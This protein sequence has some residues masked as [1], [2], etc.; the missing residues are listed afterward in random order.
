MVIE[1]ESV[2]S[3]TGQAENHTPV[4]RDIIL[5]NQRGRIKKLKQID[6]TSLMDQKYRNWVPKSVKTIVNSKY[7]GGKHII[8]KKCQTTVARGFLW[9]T[10]IRSVKLGCAAT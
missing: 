1:T 2:A 10:W 3:G 7:V 6:E 5:L 8:L 4:T 9:S